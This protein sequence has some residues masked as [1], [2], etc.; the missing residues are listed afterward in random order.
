[1]EHITNAN[2]RHPG[3]NFV[4]TLL[5]SFRMTT[6]RGTHNCMVFDV[7]CEPLWILKRRFKGNTIPLD[8]L[9]PISMLILEGLQY[10]HRECHIIHTG[11][12]SLS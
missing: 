3:R 2:P 7:L 9:K 4:A 12:S 1:M 11:K 5:E 10:L 6:P 8:L